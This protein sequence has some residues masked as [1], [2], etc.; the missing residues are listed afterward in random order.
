MS[1]ICALGW[2][3][4]TVPEATADEAIRLVGGDWIPDEKGFQGYTNGWICRG[5]TGGLGRLGTG[6]KRAPREVHVDL[7]QEL[8]SGWSYEKF[9]SVAAWVFTK[10]GHFGRIDVA[11]DDRSGVI[12]VDR[13]YASVVAG[14][15]VSHFRKSQLI[16]GLDLGSGIDTGKTLCM[17]SRQ[18]DTYLRIYD[19]AAEQRA[20]HK[21]VDGTWVR[22]EM[23][24]KGE[25]AQ[26]VGLALSVLDQERFQTY[27]VGVFRTAVDFRDCTRADE[28]KDR[29]QAPLLA[30]WKVLTDGMQRAKLEIAKVVKQIEDVK[31]WAEQSLSP[32]L[33]LLCAHPEAGERWLVKTIVDGVERWRSK[34]LALLAPG[35]DRQAVKRKMRWWNPRDGFAAAS[36]STGS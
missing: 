18:S 24:W 6:A 17:G 27:I 33:G 14:N 34:H 22:W 9:Q 30:W 8:I 16:A 4:F 10:D 32:M 5:S 3:R 29:Y 2:L 21:P 26:A 35:Q 23:E 7:S 25:R 36:A 11:M 15:C 13:I 20:K 31:Q 12:D 28:P 19:K 1:W